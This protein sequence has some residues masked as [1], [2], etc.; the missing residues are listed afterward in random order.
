[1]IKTSTLPSSL[2]TENKTETSKKGE[3]QLPEFAEPSANCINNI[4]NYSKSLK[5]LK[6][7]LINE[8]EVV[9]T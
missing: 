6:S 4:L 7:Q 2:H 5:V 9:H 1:M 3:Q 8:I